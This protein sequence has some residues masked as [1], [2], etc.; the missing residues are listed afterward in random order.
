MEWGEGGG[1]ERRQ[2]EGEACMVCM[3]YGALLYRPI[4]IPL[5]HLR[6][7]VWRPSFP[8]RLGKKQKK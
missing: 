8:C 2:G 1:R 5:S 7:S 4:Y 6:S 3:L